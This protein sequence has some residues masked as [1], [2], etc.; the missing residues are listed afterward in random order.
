MNAL[1]KFKEL[2][3]FFAFLKKYWPYEGLMLFL[4]LMGTACSLAAPFVLGKVIDDVI[5]SANKNLLLTLVFIMIGIN[6]IR[7]FVGIFSDYLNTW[8]SGRM[9]TDIKE[10]LFSNLLKMPYPYFEKNKPGEVIQVISHE[11]DKIQRF[12]TTGVVRLVNNAFTLLSL[13]V[14]LCYLN[15]KLFL[16]TLLILPVV[17]FINA[18]I[19][20]RVRDLVK[21]TGIKEGE[22]YNFYFERV[23][24]IS[25]IKLFN[26]FEFERNQLTLKTK[27]LIQLNLQNTKL[28]ALGGNGS[29]F[30]ISLSPLI[31]LLIGGY[32]VINQ[33]MTIGALVAFI[34]YCNRLIAPANDF[35]N[36]YIDY[37]KAHESA[38]RIFPYLQQPVE[39]ERAEVLLKGGHIWRIQCDQLCFSIDGTTILSNVNME[40]VSGCSYG[41]VGANGAGKSTLIKIISKLY[42]PTRG[43]IR[44]NNDQVLEDFSIN[45]WSKYVTVI[46]QHPHIFHESIRDNLI[47]AN[48]NATEEELWKSLDAV[49]LKTYVQSLPK[50]LDTLIGDGDECANPSGGQTQ[51][52]SLAR[53]LLKAADVI[54]LDE[55]TSAMDDCSAKEVLQLILKIFA[56]KI[57]VC[58][59][60]DITDAMLLDQ[61]V[62]LEQGRLVEVG[63]PGNLLISNEKYKALFKYQISGT[64]I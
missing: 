50:G 32:E 9:I 64:P 7:F 8:L 4:I 53:S 11:V 33:S 24:N 26:A 22:L 5:P 49:N 58:I 62:L 57:I 42:D 59:T 61:V 52:L 45:E 55:V 40:F 25:L 51:K 39:K 30:F 27:N 34:Q 46:T 29:S 31:I 20:R 17:I 44:I 2:K 15:Y 47:Y 23:K 60:H 41:I 1:L 37:V 28:T 63:D 21:N 54:L 35:L 13:A 16:I 19:S 56:D 48:R 6:I 12:L 43:S 38:K 10:Q 18:K 36:L 3:V 14:L